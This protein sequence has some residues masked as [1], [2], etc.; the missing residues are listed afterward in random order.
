[1]GF[2]TPQRNATAARPAAGPSDE[3]LV[4]RSVRGDRLAFEILIRRHQRPVVNYLYR[5]VGQKESARD[6][7][8]EVFLKVHLSLASFDPAFKFKTWLYRIASNCAIDHLRRKAPAICALQPEPFEHGGVEMAGAGP[9]P[10]DVLRLRELRERLDSAVRR[11]PPDFRQL[12]LLRYR[13]HC[14]Y[15]EIARIAD[16]PLGTVKNRIFRAREILRGDLADFLGPES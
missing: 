12:I 13:Q 14:R 8:Q 3:Q 15:D 5:Q 10:D 6:L 9:T 16:L 1:M 7:A 4:A 2:L 11:L